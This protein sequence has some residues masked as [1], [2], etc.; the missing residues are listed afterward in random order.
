MNGYQNDRRM[1]ILSLGL[2]A[3]MLI[4]LM[5]T[6]FKPSH[7]TASSTQSN[8]MI[9]RTFSYTIVTRRAPNSYTTSSSTGKL[10]SVNESFFVFTSDDADIHQDDNYLKLIP[11]DQLIHMQTV[12]N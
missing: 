10:V 6:V 4:L 8:P 2:Y 12:D 11:I 5:I 3:I 1:F 7:I 9:G